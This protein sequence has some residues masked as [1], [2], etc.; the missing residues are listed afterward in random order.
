MKK[1]KAGEFVKLTSTLTEIKDLKNEVHLS[2]N[3]VAYLM[4]QVEAFDTQQK[5]A[6]QALG[7]PI[8]KLL[9]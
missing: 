4:K 8:K 1:Q 5:L 6:A 3:G 9:L 7:W 2:Y